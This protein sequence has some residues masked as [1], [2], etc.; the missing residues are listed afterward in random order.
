MTIQDQKLRWKPYFGWWIVLVTGVVSGLG[1]GFYN[2]GFSALFKPI[3]S[4]LGFSR[5][6]TSV[7]AG[8]GRLEG[9]LDAPITGWLVDRFGPRWV[10][11]FG[12][13]T[14]SLGLVLM[15]SR[16]IP[17][18]LLPGLGIGYRDRSERVADDCRGQ[19]DHQ[20]VC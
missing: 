3:A 6:A 14:M 4:E 11:V 17:V 20:L 9:G 8:I 10:M 1:H 19:D 13:G 5:A 18:E 7:A 16:L 15:S 2:Y 12:L